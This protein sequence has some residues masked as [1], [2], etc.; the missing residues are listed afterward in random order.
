MEPP[1]GRRRGAEAEDLI[2][3]LPDE[4]LHCI[5]LRLPST[6]A[7]VRTSLLSRRWRP[8]WAHMPELVLSCGRP[9]GAPEPACSAFINSVD[10]ALNAYSAPTL[11]R[12]EIQMCIYARCHVP[13][14]RIARWLLF[15]SQR[16]AGRL[17]IYVPELGDDEDSDQGFDLPVCERATKI[18][19]LLQPNIVIRLPLGGSFTALTDL[20]VILS[21]MNGRELGRLVSTQCPRLRKLVIL[22]KLAGDCD[23]SIRSESLVS[24]FYYASKSRLEVTTPSLEKISVS[25]AAEAYIDAP[26][27]KKVDWRDDAY[28]PSCHQLVVGNHHLQRLWIKDTS[29]LR[30]RMFDTVKELRLD[31]SISQG[32]EGYQSFLKDTD[33]VPVCET[34]WIVSCMDHHSFAS[35]MM[36]LLGKWRSIRKLKLHADPQPPSMINHCMKLGCPCHL[37]EIYRADEI[38]FDSLEEIEIDNLTGS[39]EQEKIVMF[40]LSRCDTTKLKSVEIT[41]AYDFVSSAVKGVCEEIHSICHPNSKVKFNVMGEMGQEPF[42]F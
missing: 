4:L 12:L 32:I 34:L 14:H 40:L 9:E 26:K 42:L 23:V 10:A 16:L 31:L 35:T 38:T 29:M 11:R 5:L 17:D 15:A 6:A 22:V 36:H 37:P 1:A 2:S 21:T 8:V 41:M 28:D 13:A 24:L 39:G 18:K 19:L 25:E 30:M 33:K 20:R 3:G 27:L 7:A